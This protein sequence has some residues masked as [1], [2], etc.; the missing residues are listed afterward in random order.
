MLIK[1]LQFTQMRVQFN[2]IHI[3]SVVR[4]MPIISS[5]VK[6]KQLH[7]ALIGIENNPSERRVRKMPTCEFSNIVERF[8][9]L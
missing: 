5:G 9:A 4:L 2:W 1:D 7:Q 6:A 3:K 8:T